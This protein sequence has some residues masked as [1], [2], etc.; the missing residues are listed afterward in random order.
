MRLIRLILILSLVLT[1]HALASARGQAQLGER[2]VLCTG[3]A[4]VVVYGADG[5]PVESPY[6]CPDMALSLLAAVSPFDAAVAPAPRLLSLIVDPA[7]LP[8]LS[9]A[10][11]AA[12]ARDPPGVSPA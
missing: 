10:P 7:A 11:V 1:G 8:D 2:L 12:Q 4:V 9:V 5:A 6:F 3:H